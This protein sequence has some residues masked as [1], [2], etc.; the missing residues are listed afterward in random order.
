MCCRK[1]LA[2]AGEE[3]QRESVAQRL[4]VDQEIRLEGFQVESIVDAPAESRDPFIEDQS[5]IAFELFNLL[6]VKSKAILTSRTRFR[7]EFPSINLTGI[8]GIQNTSEFVRQEI[9]HRL[10]PV[11]YASLDTKSF[12][13]FTFL[14]T[15]KM[16][17][18]RIS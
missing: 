11:D 2:L 10:L 12:R 4:A 8:Q 7:G 1:P 17:C 14:F 13:N 9:D 6:G 15:G 5:Q 16:N 18:S 3:T